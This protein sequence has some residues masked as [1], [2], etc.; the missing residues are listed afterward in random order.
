MKMMRRRSVFILNCAASVLA[1]VLAVMYIAYSTSND[2]FVP[3]V[4]V[5][6]LIGVAGSIASMFF[7]TPM[8]PLVPCACW[9]LAFAF[10]LTD[11]LM[12]FG[13]YLN[14]LPGLS[15]GGNIIE[16]VFVIL[17]G[18]ALCVIMEIVSCFM[19]GSDKRS[20]K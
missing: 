15:G 17:I 10:F 6:L 3:A 13:D 2:T 12:M 5:L 11:R 19:I 7:E 4:F 16:L 9:S 18:I 14:G 8:L 20:E 1:L